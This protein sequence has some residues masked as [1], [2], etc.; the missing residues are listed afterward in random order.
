ML[1]PSP[2]MGHARKTLSWKMKCLWGN[3]SDRGHT[4]PP[5]FAR[6][7]EGAPSECNQTYHPDTKPKR[8]QSALPASV[9]V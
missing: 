2:G 9:S 5:K 8:G 1:N 4:S 7:H 6:G 3:L